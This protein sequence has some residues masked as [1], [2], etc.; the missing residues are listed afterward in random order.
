MPKTTK[1]QII[2]AAKKGNLAFFQQGI[3]SG[4]IEV[5]NDL[6]NLAR[7]DSVLHLAARYGHWQLLCLAEYID[8][9][10][11]NKEGLTAQN[12]AVEYGDHVKKPAATISASVNVSYDDR[13][14]AV[15]AYK[16]TVSGNV[17]KGL[18]PLSKLNPVLNY[19]AKS[20]PNRGVEEDEDR[21]Q[22]LRYHEEDPRP[23]MNWILKAAEMP[24][25]PARDKE[26]AGI[27]DF[28]SQKG[29]PT[30]E[31]N[32]RIS[33][34]NINVYNNRKGPDGNLLDSSALY[35]EVSN[36]I[37]AERE[38]LNAEMKKKLDNKAAFLSKAAAGYLTEQDVVDYLAQ[39]GNMQDATEKKDQTGLKN[40]KH[41]G[42]NA[43]HHAIENG[44]MKVAQMLLEG[45]N[46]D[47]K[48]FSMDFDQ[49]AREVFERCLEKNPHDT[50]YQK[51]KTYL[52]SPATSP[53]NPQTPA[54]P[55]AAVGKAIEAG[56]GQG[57]K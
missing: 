56:G 7:G 5:P 25:G 3:E 19:F 22:F 23:Y 40:E 39:G 8:P 29:P 14:K 26:F 20:R 32:T 37:A 1:K 11:K 10:I 44:H 21:Q 33:G 17:V 9:A 35:L 16:K 4:D 38:K 41:A 36:K 43:L 18:G 13:N 55:L 46:V 27:K 2:A 30:R 53:T 47:G 52:E 42:Y 15:E 48:N 51:F 24:A 31:E 49:R 34:G 50:K 54:L 45:V 57:R 28:I 6:V 12:I